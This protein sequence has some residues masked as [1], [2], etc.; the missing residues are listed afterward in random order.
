MGRIEERASSKPSKHHISV[1]IVKPFLPIASLSCSLHSPLFSPISSS[2][3][4]FAALRSLFFSRLPSRRRTLARSHSRAPWRDPLPFCP[5]LSRSRFRP[6]PRRPL[7]RRLHSIALSHPSPSL[8]SPFSLSPF[9]LF[10]TTITLTRSPH[11]SP[12][13]V[14]SSTLA[15]P[16]R[17]TD[18]VSVSVS[19]DYSLTLAN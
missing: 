13:E 1:Y 14:P 18:N 8:H 2:L 16:A 9:A 19:A 4:A 11:S 6:R 15:T 5:I 3:V 17:S 10:Q 12:T 7:T